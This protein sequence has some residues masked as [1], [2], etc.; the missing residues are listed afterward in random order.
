MSSLASTTI[1]IVCVYNDLAVRQECLDRTVHK[2]I[3]SGNADALVEYIPVNN[4][5]A[6]YPTAGSALNYGASIAK[7]DII[8]FV[9][10]DVLLHS[11]EAVIQAASRMEQ[12]R[13]GVLG[14]VGV[15]SRGRIVGYIRDRTM[16]LGDPVTQPTDVDSVDEL[17]FMAPRSLVMS[18]PLAESPD[19]AWHAYAVEY[20][21]RVRRR[22]LRVGV[23]Q[24]PVTHNSLTSNLARLDVA[25]ATVAAQYGEMLPVRTTCGILTKRT[26][27]GPRRVWL[28]SQRS[29]YRWLTNSL[30]LKEVYWHTTT[31]II[32]SDVRFAIDEIAERSPGRKLYILNHTRGERFADDDGEFIELKRR[33]NI[34]AATAQEVSELQGVLDRR[35]RGSWLLI[36]NM[37]SRDVRVVDSDFVQEG[38]VIGFSPSTEYWMILG[39]ELSDLPTGWYKG[40]LLSRRH[41]QYL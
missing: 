30:S 25:H 19:L 41:A 36:T 27:N 12:E 4:I 13:F 35:P 1:S 14:A 28:A 24:I 10:Q 2:Y 17:L 8:V 21:L 34:I 3:D 9:H 6:T 15:Q 18:E 31:P 20:G 22:G 38:R 29:R 39:A 26:I 23:A 40:P 16:L 11:V 33:E 37:T 32:F 5:H 7:N